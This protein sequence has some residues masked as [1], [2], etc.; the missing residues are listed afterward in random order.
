VTD[1]KGLVARLQRRVHKGLTL[2]VDLRV[3]D[4]CV[5]LFGSSATGKTSLLRSIAGL[6]QPDSGRILLDGKPIFDS[7]SNLN[8]PLRDRHI[9]MISQKHSLFPHLDVSANIR[10]GLS[11]WPRPESE[12]RV[13]EIARL[14]GLAD[15][16]SSRIEWLSG[17]E[18]QR[19]ALARALAPRPRLL[20]CDE[21]FSSLDLPARSLLVDSFRSIRSSEHIPTLF[22]THSTAEAVTLGDRMLLF[23]SGKILASCPPIDAFGLGWPDGSPSLDLLNTLA[24]SVAG[25]SSDALATRIQLTNG[26]EL[27]VPRLNRPHGAPVLLLIRAEDILLAD[28]AEGAP[29]LSAR[30]II[31][32]VVD[33]ILT[34]GAEAEVLVRTGSTQWIVSLVSGAVAEMGLAPGSNCALVIKARSCRV[35]DRPVVGP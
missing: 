2:D 31:P 24:G 20:L 13:A 5:V 19:V 7:S 35:V 32:G 34:H 15:L 28:S 33:R 3:D 4:E 10:F 11:H 6:D 26:P 22:V 27:L 14:C 18:C 12:R 25:E 17:G 8:L 23:E 30:N 29:L 9:G 1:T 16:I 21:P